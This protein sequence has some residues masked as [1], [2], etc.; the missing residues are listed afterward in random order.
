MTRDPDLLDEFGVTVSFEADRVV[1]GVWGEVDPVSAPEL[2]T[3][4]DAVIDRGHTAVVLDLASLSFMDASGLRVI[5]HGVNR[6]TPVG[7]MLTIRSAPTNVTRIL[8]ITGLHEVISFEGPHHPM[9]PVLDHRLGP[10]Q[11]VRAP[12]LTET[13]EVGELAR[14]LRHI[15][16][17]PA[18]HDVVDGAL[19][20]VV[21]LARATVERADGVS[22][23]LQRH[24]R[25]TSVAATDQTVVAMDADQYTTGEGP[26]V[27]A[28]VEGR[29]FHVQSLDDETRWPAFI[30]QAR[31]LGIRSILSSPLMVEDQPAG[32]LNIYSRTEAAFTETEQRLAAIFATEA[33]AILKDAGVDVSTDQLSGRVRGAL[34][35]RR[36]IAQAEGVVM[37]REGVSAD[38]AYRSLLDTS[39]RTGQPVA[40]L[41]AAVVHSTRQ[42]S[43]VR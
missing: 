2:A 37:E 1:L 10:E 32:A 3:V 27:S 11:S 29:W 19:R 6:L 25:L 34:D 41:A 16:A 35:V 15:T 21:A 24:G 8:E 40:E 20:L 5:A 9:E 14:Q 42:V 30:P 7:G 31:E 38:G 26:C 36:T 28:S 23:S 18:D 4:L 39:R 17:I 33:S 22:V 13:A 43:D 12:D